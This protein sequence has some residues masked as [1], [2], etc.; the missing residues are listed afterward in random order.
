MSPTPAPTRTTVTATWI[1]DPADAAR[2]VSTSIV[3]A[4]A[5]GADGVAPDL[6]GHELTDLGNA[7]RLLVHHHQRLRYAPQ[8]GRWLVWDGRRFRPDVLGAHRELA[9]LTVRTLAEQV[10]A[11]SDRYQADSNVSK[12]AH[13]SQRSGRINAMIDLARSDERVVVADAALDADPNL[14]NVA[15]GTIDLSTGQLHPHDPALLLTKLANVTYDPHASCPRWQRFLTE[16]FGD[17][18]ELLTYLQ[19]LVGYMLTA[20]VSDQSVLVLYGDGAN[21]KTTWLNTLLALV[22]DYGIQTT[23]DLLLADKRDTH[24]TGLTDLQGI[25]VAVASETPAGRSLDEE[26]IKKLAGGDLIRAR[27]MRQDNFEFAATHKLLLATNHRPNITGRDYG[28]WRR[29]R[30]LPMTATFDTTRRDPTLEATLRDELPGILA[31]AVEGAVAWYADRKL[32]PPQI[33]TDATAAY[34]QETDPIGGFI[35]ER[36]RLDDK[37]AITTSADL[38]TAYC[39]W[40]HLAGERALSQRQ[41]SP[42]LASHGL[43][44]LKVHGPSRRAA[45]RGVTLTSAR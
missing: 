16:V 43:T 35:T 4:A 36:C 19:R 6:I 15:N 33:I 26:L 25:R 40:A 12:H 8:Q 13:A 2:P 28:I 7:E 22:G 24:T 9:K 32:D 17:D 42:L 18:Q 11:S 10:A 39:N 5:A 37:Q 31:W 3:E 41:L 14:F 45:W 20:E 30:A 27:R 29:I 1:L 34:R 23:S 21:G 38:Y 44:H